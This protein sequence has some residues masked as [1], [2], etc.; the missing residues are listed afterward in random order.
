MPD[1]TMPCQLT[2]IPL[3]SLFC[4]A[5][6]FPS[7]G[8]NLVT[9]AVCLEPKESQAGNLEVGDAVTRLID[10]SMEEPVSWAGGIAAFPAILELGFETP[11]KPWY[12]VIR[13]KH[14]PAEYAVALHTNAGWQEIA[15]HVNKHSVV[16]KLM[17]HFLGELE[18]NALRIVVHRTR[19]NDQRCALNAIEIYEREGAPQ[20]V[21]DFLVRTTPFLFDTPEHLA[22]RR[23]G[24]KGKAP[25]R[26]VLDT[27]IPTWT[28]ITSA[29]Y[30]GKL[31]GK[32]VNELCAQRT[33]LLARAVNHYVET[34]NPA[35]AKK[36]WAVMETIIEHYDRYQA[37][38]FF[39][40]KWQA[41][42][43]QE[44]GY[45]LSSL[46]RA[47]DRIADTL[48][49][50]Q[51]LRTLYFL[52]DVGDFQ[53]RTLRDIIPTPGNV[54]SRG[55]I[56]NWVPNS[57]GAL[58]LTACFLRDFPEADAWIS[59]V[60]RKIAGVFNPVF[61][62]ADGSWWECS[63]AHHAYVLRGICQ[64]ALAKHLLS[65]PVWDR[66]F[67]EL[68][69]ADAFDALAKTANPLGEFPSVNDSYGHEKPIR[70][71]Y[72][73]FVEAATM[74]GRGDMLV[75]WRAQPTWP[76]VPGLERKSVALEPPQCTSVLMPAAGHAVMRDGWAPDDAYLFFDY[77]PHGGGHGHLDKLS[78]ALVADGRHW[79]PDAACAPH[80]CIFPEQWS[81]HKQTI[82]HNTVLVDGRSQQE[83]TGR[84]IAW[85]TDDRVDIVSANHDGNRAS[86]PMAVP[87]RAG[88]HR[89]VILPR[90]LAP[91][92]LASVTLTP[93]AG[94]AVQL[95]IAKAQLRNC[96]VVEDKAA[97]GGTAIEF[98]TRSASA[99]WDVS[100]PAGLYAVALNGN[101]RAGSHDS[102]YI[103]LDGKRIG[104]CGLPD[105]T[106]DTV[107]PS[108]Y[109]E[110]NHRRTI[111]H[112]RGEYFLIHDLLSADTG[113]RH[114]LEWLLHVYGEPAAQER[115]RIVFRHG[116]HGLL[117]VS[118]QI[119]E[120]PLSLERGLVGGLEASKWHGDGYPGKG[121]PGWITIPYLKLPQELDAQIGPGRTHFWAVI[122]P[123]KGDTVP[124][125]RIE[126]LPPNR[127]A[128]G[129]RIVSEAGVDTF[130]EVDVIKPGKRAA[131]AV[132]WQVGDCE[133]NA[134]I[135]FVRRDSTGNRWGRAYG[136]TAIAGGT[137]L[138]AFERLISAPR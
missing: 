115:G 10:A 68:T 98:R 134:G 15:R 21:L 135:A 81:W 11:C 35:Y 76:T 113:Q 87:W 137:R 103:E 119:A 14:M 65:D 22:E 69:I 97:P 37:F 32:R 47:Y 80:Y 34:G 96:V 106:Y 23:A 78:I 112:L 52:L 136:G 38:R 130:V 120:T 57:M 56:A 101:G 100:L 20:A 62:L 95:P 50:E 28:P 51:K 93:V 48:S 74:M 127:L 123:F 26:D 9:R 36:A 70:D 77:G 128:T 105:R 104:E 6:S 45:R 75:A 111:L 84:L 132:V 122:L 83:T 24:S 49:A 79:V 71:S 102:V 19:E 39:G 30:G 92:R 67:G 116:K 82:S 88:E 12:I 110:V 55:H 2:A 121:D 108:M 8:E 91:F 40:M 18:T 73:E 1:L 7:F 58:A 25:R 44:P 16:D 133:G 13:W 60:D 107:E 131:P 117:V 31:T 118:P 138:T 41:V 3:L 29:Q 72:G 59:E 4:V 99:G 43:F 125:L 86:K 63:P 126:R 94:D 90:E 42:T 114:Q 46:P 54:R 5:G 109:V 129:I 64:Y 53:C 85:H 27:K 33:L 17:L 66:R 124:E 61:F 89:L